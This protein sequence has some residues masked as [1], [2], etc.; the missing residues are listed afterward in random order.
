MPE[1]DIHIKGGTIVAAQMGDRYLRMLEGCEPTIA[2]NVTENLYERHV[3][4]LFVS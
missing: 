1:F 4:P 3:K 2:R